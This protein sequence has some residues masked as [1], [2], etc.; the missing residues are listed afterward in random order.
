[1]N[2]SEKLADTLLDD[3][4]RTAFVYL[5][6]LDVKIVESLMRSI[7]NQQI[8]IFKEFIETMELPDS[9]DKMDGGKYTFHRWGQDWYC[10]AQHDLIKAILK[11]LDGLPIKD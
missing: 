3:K 8:A 2:I 7:A 9:R 4:L 10:Q 6:Q 11:E 5:N 1:M